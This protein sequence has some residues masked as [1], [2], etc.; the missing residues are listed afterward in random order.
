MQ[1]F[2]R[3]HQSILY[4]RDETLFLIA[5]VGQKLNSVANIS[6]ARE[7]VTQLKIAQYFHSL[8]I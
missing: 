6:A 8:S 7:K 2:I 5:F 4:D 3:S 1:Y